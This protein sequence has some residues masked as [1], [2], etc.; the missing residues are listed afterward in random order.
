MDR[1]RMLSMVMRSLARERFLDKLGMSARLIWRGSDGQNCEET[2]QAKIGCPAWTRTRKYGSKGR[3]VTNYT[4]GQSVPHSSGS[5]R[6]A[7]RA[8][9]NFV[10]CVH[11]LGRS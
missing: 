11:I 1:R 7:G 2:R 3:C 4:T 9:A 8:G 10:T 6:Y 5:H